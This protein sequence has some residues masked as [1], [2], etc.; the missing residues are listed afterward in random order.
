MKKLK[1]KT[2]TAIKDRVGNNVAIATVEEECF[3][4][5]IPK[6]LPPLP[7]DCV[8]LGRGPLRGCTHKVPRKPMYVFDERGIL[9][10]N[11]AWDYYSCLRGDAPKLHYAVH[12]DSEFVQQ[13]YPE[14]VAAMKPA[15]KVICFS[16][17]DCANVRV[18]KALVDYVVNDLE[19]KLRE[20]ILCQL[21]DSS[22]SVSEQALV[23]PIGKF[24]VWW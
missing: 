23:P 7:S 8:Y 5:D 22:V 13:Y 1:F 2:E 21:E 12:K 24:G 3:P 6:G 15:S 4:T 14:F 11:N 18:E 20:A 9:T 16:T 19:N 17:S 10:G